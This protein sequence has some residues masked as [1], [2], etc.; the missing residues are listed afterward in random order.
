MENKNE[1]AEEAKSKHKGSSGGKP[2]TR[3]QQKAPAA[4][5]LDQMTAINAGSNN[6]GSRSAIPL[7]SP[8]ILSP[9]PV[10]LEREDKKQLL[11]SIEN[12]DHDGEKGDDNN[13]YDTS[14]PTQPSQTNGNV[15]DPSSLFTFFQPQCVLVNLGP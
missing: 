15:E 9:L 1:N 2:P 14:A 4:L 3:L 5:Q 12:D 13:N 8:L 7:L 6:D 11:K 10:Q